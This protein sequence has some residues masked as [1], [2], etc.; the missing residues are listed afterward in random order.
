MKFPRAKLSA[1]MKKNML[2]P[3]PIQIQGLPVVLSGRDMIWISFTGSGKALVFVLP[4][5]M[6]CLEQEVEIPFGS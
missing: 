6:L 5:I 4:L 2:N 1:L 3:S